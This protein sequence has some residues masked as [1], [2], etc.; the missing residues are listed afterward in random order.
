MVY[1][2]VSVVDNE[3]VARLNQVLVVMVTR[4]RCR[5]DYELLCTDGTR[6]SA[7]NAQTCNWGTVSSHIA[8]TSAMRDQVTRNE[9]KQLLKLMS[10]D[11]GMMSLQLSLII[12]RKV[13]ILQVVCWKKVFFMIFLFGVVLCRRE[14]TTQ[15]LVRVV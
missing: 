1:V 8:M 4:V 9:Y 7:E 11:F 3:L 12:L 5:Q 15:G 10:D 14:R 13:P 2:F 6:Q